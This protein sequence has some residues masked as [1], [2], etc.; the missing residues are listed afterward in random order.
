MENQVMYVLKLVATFSVLLPIALGFWRLQQYDLIIKAF[1]LFLLTGL[2]V[3]LAGWHFYVTR[4]E[5]ANLY[6]RHFYDLFEILFLFWF[7]GQA[8]PD[9]LTKL[10]F[11][12]AWIVVIPFWMTRFFY[13]ETISV[14][15]ISTEVFIAFAACFSILRR[16]EVNAHA[17]RTLTFWLLLGVFFYC[18]STYFIMGLLATHLSK[19]WYTH[20]IINILTNVIYLVG[21]LKT[22]SLSK[23]IPAEF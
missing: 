9:R 18:F 12:N 7:L 11:A 4:N 10:L 14:F 23:E 20:N 3:D 13:L 15:R 17:T 22:R 8:S 19:L 21:F 6:T 2:A 5:A 16:V 1:L